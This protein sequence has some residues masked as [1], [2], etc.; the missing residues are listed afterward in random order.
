MKKMILILTALILL[1]VQCFAAEKTN[2]I[3]L[4]TE[5]SYILPLSARPMNLQN[6]NPRAVTVEAVTNI[7]DADSSL[8]ITTLEEGIAYISFKQKNKVVTLKILVDNK[9]HEDET[10]IKLD[11]AP[12]NEKTE[13]K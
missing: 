9:E 3:N 4:N 5:N 10:L 13:S 6:S 1:P 7:E 12:E 2:I 8:L 11:K